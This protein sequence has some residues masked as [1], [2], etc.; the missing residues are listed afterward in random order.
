MICCIQI[1]KKQ[2]LKAL[3]VYE[4]L[5]PLASGFLVTGFLVSGFWWLAFW[6]LASGSYRFFIW[7]LFATRYFWI[8]VI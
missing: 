7:S 5:W 8:V 2:L 4:N 6:C 1:D 3:R